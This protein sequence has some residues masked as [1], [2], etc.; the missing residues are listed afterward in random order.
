MCIDTSFEV[1]WCT[2]CN[3]MIS[4]I[5]LGDLGPE[6][7]DRNSR[8][9]RALMMHFAEEWSTAEGPDR[10]HWVACHDMAVVS[11]VLGKGL[12]EQGNPDCL[13]GTDAGKQCVVAISPLLQR[14]PV[15]DDDCVRDAKGVEIDAVDSIRTQRVLAVEEHSLQSVGSLCKCGGADDEPA[16]ANEALTNVFG[17]DAL[18][19]E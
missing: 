19:A 2:S 8:R 12:L 15:V 13:I 6:G 5:H 1:S 17:S 10:V 4:A 9:A 11:V 16:V 18:G 7:I 14:Q 3:H